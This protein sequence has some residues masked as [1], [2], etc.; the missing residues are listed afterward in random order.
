MKIKI[1]LDLLN[2]KCNALPMEQA[3]DPGA[4]FLVEAHAGG[5]RL[6][7]PNSWQA[8]AASRRAGADAIELDVRRSLDGALC[9]RHAC[10][11]P[12]G[13]HACQLTRRE[14]EV[15]RIA[16]A[17]LVWLDDVLAWAVSERQRLVLDVKRD[18]SGDPAV[19]L[20]EV[21][22]LIERLDAAEC[23]T[24][25]SYD[26][27]ELVALRRR[28][29]ARTRPLLR[30]RPLDLGGVLAAAQGDEVALFADDASAQDAAIARDLGLLTVLVGLRELDAER[31]A[32]LGVDA[33]SW[34][35]PASARA[36]LAGLRPRAESARETVR[37]VPLLADKHHDEPSVFVPAAL[38]RQARRQRGVAEGS[39]PRTCVLDPDGDIVR[40]LRATGAARR[41][42]SWACYHTELDEFDL[43]SGELG[44]VGGAVGAPFAVLVAEQLRASG[45]GLVISVTSA[46]RVGTERSGFMLIE[47]AL[48][49]EGTSLHYRPPGPTA[50][51]A[52]H[53]HAPLRAL[54]DEPTTITFSGI[55][56]TTDAPFRETRSA[57]DRHAAAGIACVEM[58]A[59]ALYAYA[60]ATGARVVCLAHLTNDL[61]RSEIDFEK[62]DTDGAEQALSIVAR[63][64]DLLA[65]R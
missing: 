1:S 46:G 20:D 62:G 54:F 36:A 29:G 45:C 50:T 18:G 22:G 56:W 52:P 44:V 11:L 14:L 28:T 3:S 48:R 25:A 2:Y 53:L 47:R 17:P 39:V 65:A 19:V 33:V 35:D 7:A 13:R 58:E 9:L 57:L 32:V 23:V 16:D 37:G 64:A 24:V 38:L 4:R 21:A 5:D 42:A 15:V 61:G 59:A 30:G 31:A 34:G 26:H 49:D 40:Y 8:I 63:V 43:A 12:D 51:L 60:E 55:S 27:A 10:E 6:A 41:S